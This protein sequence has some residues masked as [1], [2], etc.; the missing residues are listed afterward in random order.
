LST[1][2]AVRD[3]NPRQHL[4]TINHAVSSG[5]PFYDSSGR[6][7]SCTL[8]TGLPVFVNVL[9]NDEPRV[10]LS[11]AEIAVTEGGPSAVYAMKLLARPTSDVMFDLIFDQRVVRVEPAVVSF[12]AAGWDSSVQTVVRVW[13]VDD[14]LEQDD[15][16]NDVDGIQTATTIQHR[17]RTDDPF[18]SNVEERDLI[19]PPPLPVTVTDNDFS[20]VLLDPP[21]NHIVV[22]ENG[23]LG[24]YNVRLATQ[25]H[26]DVI[27]YPYPNNLSEAVATGHE[28]YV[29]NS[30]VL[31]F[32]AANWNVTQPGACGS[33]R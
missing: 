2:T 3:H 1:A 16:I 19:E 26:A 13:A 30:S 15:T 29:V 33:S 6:S 21:E 7:E 12:A 25:P 4:G 23:M 17:V 22:R 28:I 32:T 11:K 5:D 24:Q 31:V 10:F 18:Y 14:D 9:D 8:P 20:A 27:L